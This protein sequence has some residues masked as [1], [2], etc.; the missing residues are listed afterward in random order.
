MLDTRGKTRSPKGIFGINEFPICTE[1]K[2]EKSVRASA[3]KD[4]SEFLGLYILQN[5]EIETVEINTHL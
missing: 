2:N 5:A 4:A 3:L 1:K